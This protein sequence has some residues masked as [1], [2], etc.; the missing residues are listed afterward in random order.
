MDPDVEGESTTT[1]WTDDNEELL[2][3]TICGVGSPK[4]A[5]KPQDKTDHLE[6]GT[7][8]T[9]VFYHSTAIVS[10]NAAAITLRFP[11]W[12][13]SKEIGSNLMNQTA[14]KYGLGYHMHK[15]NGSWYVTLPD[16]ETTVHYSDGMTFGRNSNWVRPSGD[17]I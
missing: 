11:E 13:G 9:Q 6:T 1:Y 7:L 17:T 10:F 5:V 15:K 14:N 12:R 8:V 4:Y 2:H 3:K 16:G